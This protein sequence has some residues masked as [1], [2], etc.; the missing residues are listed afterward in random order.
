MDLQ[1][2]PDLRT[3]RRL[4]GWTQERFAKLTGIPQT[5][6]WRVENG[7]ATFSDEEIRHVRRLL[8]GLEHSVSDAGIER[9]ARGFTS[10][11]VR[12]FRSM[13]V[14]LLGRGAT[15][16]QIELV[17]G[18]AVAAVASLLARRNL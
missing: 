6:I 7:L 8:E 3:V 11:V 4:L 1:L 14:E 17:G 9:V 16:Q 2:E 13:R 12:R 18:R 10:D 5:K 15:Q